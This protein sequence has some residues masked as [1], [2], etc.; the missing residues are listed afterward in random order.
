MPGMIP[1][2]SPL[3]VSVSQRVLENADREVLVLRKLANGPDEGTD[4]EVAAY[5]LQTCLGKN[6][7]CGRETVGTLC[8]FFKRDIVPSDEDK[9]MLE[10]AA[11]AIGIEEDRKRADEERKA[12]EVR[13]DQK[14]VIPS[15]FSET[16]RVRAAQRLGADP[17]VKKPYTLEKIG[18]TVKSALRE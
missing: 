3:N 15:G 18:L 11:S 17:Y 9:R 13:P 6:V 8:V 2:S 7:E 1:L 12:L 4:P 10:L 14:A 16:D 5:N